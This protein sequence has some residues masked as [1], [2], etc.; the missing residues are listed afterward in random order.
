MY[1]LTQIGANFGLALHQS[2]SEP[3]FGGRQHVVFPYFFS[4]SGR[5]AETAVTSAV[6]PLINT[7]RWFYYLPPS[8]SE[9]TFKTYP[10]LLAFDVGAL[11]IQ[12]MK[13]YADHITADLGIS[14]EL[15]IIGSED[16]VVPNTQNHGR[17]VLL[18]PSEGVDWLCYEGDYN[19]NCNGCVPP[20]YNL[21]EVEDKR[22]YYEALK[23]GCGY[24]FTTGGHGNQYVDYMVNEVLPAIKSLTNNRLKTD[25]DNLGI[26]GCSLGGVMACHSAYTRPETFSFVFKIFEL[27]LK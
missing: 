11:F 27:L 10:T 2:R 1:L 8:F 23:N 15:V 17:Y 3:Y 22:L 12:E 20:E 4:R 21:F 5:I 25:R 18:T 24:P 26:S 13:S 7:R 14:E 16:Y 6:D 19:D 9:N